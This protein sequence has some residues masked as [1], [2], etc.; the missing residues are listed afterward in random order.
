MFGNDI[1]RMNARLKR[2][3]EVADGNNDYIGKLID[4]Q[5]VTAKVV[6]DSDLGTVYAYELPEGTKRVYMKGTLDGTATVSTN[7]TFSAAGNEPFARLTIGANKKHT[8]VDG[9]FVFDPVT[10]TIADY[11]FYADSTAT[12]VPDNAQVVSSN[13]THY[14]KNSDYDFSDI[15][16][17]GLPEGFTNNLVVSAY[18][19]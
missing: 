3:E 2:T 1:V 8:M 18:P 6:Q 16:I 11:G 14:F 19:N 15:F 5:E 12:D 10:G 17:V 7:V 4:G 9:L 13:F